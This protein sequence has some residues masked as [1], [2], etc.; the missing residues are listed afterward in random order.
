MIER[1]TDTSGERTVPVVT[2]PGDTSYALPADQMERM[3]PFA[4]HLS[5]HDAISPGVHVS[6]RPVDTPLPPNHGVRPLESN[7]DKSTVGTFGT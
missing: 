5:E 6:E 2:F 1:C 4:R 3:I 7:L